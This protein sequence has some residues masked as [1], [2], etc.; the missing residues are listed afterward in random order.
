MVPCQLQRLLGP[1]G[2]LPSEKRRSCGSCFG[3][4]TNLCR[5]ASIG[6][7]SVSLKLAIGYTPAY[8]RV[9]VAGLVSI[10]KKDAAVLVIATGSI[11]GNP[12][13]CQRI[14]PSTE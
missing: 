9:D 11:E 3:G 2:Y 7:E 13:E 8:C 6:T 1:Q 12:N 5:R 14:L 4:A 10:R